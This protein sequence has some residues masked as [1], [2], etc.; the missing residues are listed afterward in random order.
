MVIA[1]EQF[2]QL[3]DLVAED[4]VSRPVWVNESLAQYFGLKAIERSGL[5]QSSLA[6]IRNRFIEPDRKVEVPLLT[7]SRR[8]AAGDRS[9]Y[10]LFYSQGA[11]FWAELDRVLSEGSRG[12]QTLGDLLPAL[13]QLEFDEAGMLPEP[14]LSRLRSV[15]GSKID[16]LVLRF[17]GSWPSVQTTST[18]SSGE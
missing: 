7:L 6:H 14:F 8:Y 13:L 15:A 4:R 11:T 5:P 10:P 1:H 17:V 16:E 3:T 9:V 12:Q 18:D 2:H